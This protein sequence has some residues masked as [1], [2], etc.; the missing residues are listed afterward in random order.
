MTTSPPRKAKLR[1]VASSYSEWV[2]ANSDALDDLFNPNA[3]P[4]PNSVYNTHVLEV[5]A[6]SEMMDKFVA[7]VQQ[8]INSGEIK[9][10]EDLHPLLAAGDP[11]WEAHEHPRGS[12]G[13]FIKKGTPEYDV[14]VKSLVEKFKAAA[15]KAP[16]KAGKKAAKKVA[17]GKSPASL[18]G[19]HPIH[20][21]TNVIY[22]QEYSD[23]QVVAVK[24]H[25][26][27]AKNRI[28]WDGV[29][30][31]F[32]E[33][34]S[35]DDGKTWKTIDALGKGAAYQKFSQETGWVTPDPDEHDV[36]VDT[37]VK[38]IL[39]P[40]GDALKTNSIPYE[41]MLSADQA[42]ID[43]WFEELTSMTW[44]MMTP[45][46]KSAIYDVA[47]HHADLGND[48]PSDK[49]DALN[50]GPALLPPVPTTKKATTSITTPIPISP[51]EAGE[52]NTVPDF[53]FYT[54]AA[55]KEWFADLN[56]EDWDKFGDEQQEYLEES[57]EQLSQN[58]FSSAAILKVK[59]FKNQSAKATAPATVPNA[60]APDDAIS[61]L[62]ELFGPAKI[63]PKLGKIPSPEDLMNTLPNFPEY[64]DDQINKWFGDLTKAQYD[65]LPHA[66]QMDLWDYVEEE[67]LTNNGNP[68][69]K[70]T[71]TGKGIF[72]PTEDTSAKPAFT[73]LGVNFPDAT[74]VPNFGKMTYGEITAWYITKANFDDFGDSD[75]EPLQNVADQLAAI[76]I[77]EPAFKL[78][79]Y[80]LNKSKPNALNIKKDLTADEVDE[81]T[82][83]EFKQYVTVSADVIKSY[84]TSPF[85][86]EQVKKHNL[87][88]WIALTLGEKPPGYSVNPNPTTLKDITPEAGTSVGDFGQTLHNFLLGQPNIQSSTAI[89]VPQ[90]SPT[91]TSFKSVT[92]NNMLDIQT[93]ML[94]NAGKSGWT[95]KDTQAIQSYT[96]SVGYQ[97]T[98]AVLRND[99]KR[100]KNFTS[101]QLKEGAQRALDLQSTML[102]L[103]EDLLLH[104]GTGAHAFGFNT[105]DV[106]PEKLKQLEGKTI[107]DR[108][109]TSTSIVPPSNVG[110]DYASKPIKILIRA[111]KGTPATFVTHATPSWAKENEL[112]LAAGTNF[113]ISS[114]EP[115]SD[116]DKAKYGAGIKHIVIMD[117]VP[118]EGVPAN[119]IQ[120]GAKVKT[121]AG[122]TKVPAP[123]APAP[124]TPSIPVT[125]PKS[126]TKLTPIKLNTATIYKT[127]Y[128]NGATVAIRLGVDSHGNPS[129][130]RIIW[131]GINKKFIH[132]LGTPSGTWK[133]Y[134]GYSKKDTFE[135]FG[136]DTNWFAPPTSMGANLSSNDALFALGAPTPVTPG[137]SVTPANPN[138]SDFENLPGDIPP[139]LIDIQ[140]K[141]IFD[142]FKDGGS[143]GI[144]G[145]YAS[146]NGEKKFK[147]LA[148]VTHWAN[149]KLAPL[150]L[151]YLQVI[152]IVDQESAKKLGI[153]ND[154]TYT[155]SVIE[156]LKTPAGKKLAI[157]IAAN[158]HDPAAIAKLT[159]LPTSP[160]VHAP[161]TDVAT[162]LAGMKNGPEIGQP[163]TTATAFPVLSVL[164]AG[165]MQ[166][167]MNKIGGGFTA[168]QRAAIKDYTGSGSTAINSMLY[169]KSK[170]GS[171][172]TAQKVAAMQSAMKPV[173]Q[174]FVAIRNTESIGSQFDGYT[175]AEWIAMAGKKIAHPSFF[176]TSIGGVSSFENRKLKITVEV[177]EGTPAVFAR[178]ISAHKGENELLL[179]AG[180]K[181]EIISVVPTG[182]KGYGTRYNIRMRVVPS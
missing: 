155:K 80:M 65:K 110:F 34:G 148:A 147:V 141:S 157:E 44:K 139:D 167:A 51:K 140:L 177:P 134:A 129:A 68:F 59:V 61:K 93:L 165:E 146:S 35:I 108:G 58:H 83:E 119:E 48:Y 144:G 150:K 8:K 136:K 5:D 113:K 121:P 19:G 163:I 95:P 89:S 54:W 47:E 156:W 11:D 26:T 138:V 64:T 132:Q 73:S 7:N 72:K 1:A 90:Y 96:T 118:D 76:G 120:K 82:T 97:T 124:P 143:V 84:G 57:A 98:N 16:K 30:K 133:S 105:I 158:E 55:A 87:E 43:L 170:H 131:N 149:K 171:V 70:N 114:V 46:L 159:T 181:Y 36:D 107:K 31:K 172:G 45:E 104:R 4:D 100:M 69:P 166:K 116:A 3:Y 130:E 111:P 32:L 173:P 125:P 94:L 179:A 25:P 88:A 66:T 77:P 164:E 99:Q 154:G 102:P 75:L 112:I 162:V 81:L 17:A 175:E 91:K 127:S 71:L 101:Q 126:A 153:A 168:E 33:Q 106:T 2:A 18:G 123:V 13:K 161:S 145:V 174:S 60:Y 169:G 86:W 79:Q 53:D 85:F 62:D 49:I 182:N 67:Q 135:K 78:N 128:T 9:A 63:D 39:E 24:T 178:G 29:Q 74:K 117:V 180:L 142:E 38:P 12:D 40:V 109:F 50:A 137:L 14:A 23:G 27:G 52:T 152:K 41:K 37:D 21:N 10:N 151:N 56:Q 15:K 42:Q 122:T 176:G 160:N 103:T 6:T 20:I 115:A 22:K 92:S 28:V